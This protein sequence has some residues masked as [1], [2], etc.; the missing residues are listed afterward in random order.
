MKTVHALLIGVSLIISALIFGIFFYNA[1]SSVN[2]IN[3]VGMATKRFD[4]DIVKWRI[5]IGRNTGLGD[6][7]KGYSLIQNDLQFLKKLLSEKGLSE[8][9]TS[10]QPINTMSNYS[11]EGEV[12]GYNI[13]QSIFVITSN[14]SAVEEI[15]LNPAALIEKGIILQNSDLEYF[16]SKLSDIKMELLAEATKDAQKRAE[17]IAKNSNVHLGNVTNL[18]VGVFQ[19]TEPFS[20]EVSD[21]GMYNTRTKQKDIT[22]TVRASFKIQ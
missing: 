15:A 19:I 11:R 10:I 22:V 1:R 4:S 21:Y 2:T 8:R 14:L 12:S 9:E 5:T 7:T 13:Q 6:V 18:R 3:V 17:E 20:T 16:Y